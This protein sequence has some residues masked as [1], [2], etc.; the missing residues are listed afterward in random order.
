[1]I[2]VVPPP[3]P[4]KPMGLVHRLPDDDDQEEQ[5]K[6]LEWGL[7]RRL[8][9]YARPVRG[10]LSALIGLSVIRSAQL[11][12]LGWCSNAAGVALNRARGKWFAHYSPAFMFRPISAAARTMARRVAAHGSN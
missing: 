8:F 5:F 11:P 3:P 4:P 6:P 12:A 10:K 2:P 9:T 7:M 1:M